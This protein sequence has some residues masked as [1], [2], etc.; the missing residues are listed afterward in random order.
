MHGLILH[1]WLMYDEAA[2]KQ[3]DEHFVYVAIRV[4]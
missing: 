3:M 4:R 1:R 2:M